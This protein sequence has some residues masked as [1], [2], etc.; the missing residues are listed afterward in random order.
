M[1]D[2]TPRRG[3]RADGTPAMTPAEFR[4][5]RIL[6]GFSVPRTAEIVKVHERS[7]RKWE[8]GD[9][10]VPEGIAKSLDKI[11]RDTA[12]FVDKV[13]S[14]RRLD[15]TWQ[16]RVPVSRVGV[17]NRHLD[18]AW[19]NWPMEWW[20]GVAGRALDANRK[21]RG[22]FVV[23]VDAEQEGPSMRPP[24]IPDVPRPPRAN[25]PHTER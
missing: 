25:E 5:T 1:P 9:N 7:V 20:W 13:A 22:S 19:G 23:Y 11:C 15:P 21:A 2:D 4:A 17:E 14:K 8:A 3:L 6:L 10:A 12:L 16:F 24:S 18:D